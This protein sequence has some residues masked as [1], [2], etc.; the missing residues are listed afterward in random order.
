MEKPTVAKALQKI[1]KKRAMKIKESQAAAEAVPTLESAKVSPLSVVAKKNYEFE[2][3]ISPP[4]GTFTSPIR[5]IKFKFMAYLSRNEKLAM[6]QLIKEIKNN[7]EDNF[8]STSAILDRTDK[9]Y[10]VIKAKINEYSVDFIKGLEILFDGILKAKW[11][12]RT[13]L[14]IVINEQGKPAD[15][16]LIKSNYNEIQ[17]LIKN[18]LESV[19][20]ELQPEVGEDLGAPQVIEIQPSFIETKPS[21]GITQSAFPSQRDLLAKLRESRKKARKLAKEKGKQKAE[22]AAEA[23]AEAQEEEEEEEEGEEEEEEEEEQG[24]A[25]SAAAAAPKKV[26][27]KIVK[28]GKGR[29][30]KTPKVPKVP[31]PKVSKPPKQDLRKIRGQKVRELM[32]KEKLTLAQASK[33]LKEMEA[34]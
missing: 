26:K 6:D 9:L 25:S 15:V 17:Q 14:D 1:F 28:K 32:M 2:V 12:G 4:F 23:A 5:Q 18:K 11:K 31:K 19:E 30:A 3:S 13:G 29:P 22:A 33:K 21:F 16:P 10:K 7:F 20:L 24:E 8:G 27:V 34:K